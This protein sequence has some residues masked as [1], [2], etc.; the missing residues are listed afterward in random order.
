L[1]LLNQS[2]ETFSLSKQKMRA[3]VRLQHSPGE[4][5]RKVAP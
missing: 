5:K 4:T 3:I 1:K 2:I